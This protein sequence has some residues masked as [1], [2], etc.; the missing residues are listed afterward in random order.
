[1]EDGDVSS[2]V[3]PGTAGTKPARARGIALLVF[4]MILRSPVSKLSHEQRLTGVFLSVI[5]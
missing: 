1:M 5:S 4:H 3:L 2:N